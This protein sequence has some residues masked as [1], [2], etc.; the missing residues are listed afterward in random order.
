V[1]LLLLHIA[2]KSLCWT[3]ERQDEHGTKPYVNPSLGG[4]L[5]QASLL[6][7]MAHALLLRSLSPCCP[8]ASWAGAERLP[9]CLEG[10]GAHACQQQQQQPATAVHNPGTSGCEYL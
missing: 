8:C 1:L 4:H 6:K 7:P 2:L 5:Q 3:D 10:V 9:S